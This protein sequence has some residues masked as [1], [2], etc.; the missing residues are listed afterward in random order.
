MIRIDEKHVVLPDSYGY[1]AA[2]D[3]HKTNKQGEPVYSNIGYYS[4]LPGAIS[5]VFERK[6]RM[7]LADG[8]HDMADTI[9]IVRELNDE[10]RE[11]I[12]KAFPLA[13]ER[14]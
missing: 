12:E 1:T 6:K 13:E 7:R 2:I 8:E 10:A 4:T 11:M 5:S 9:R 14:K 3:T